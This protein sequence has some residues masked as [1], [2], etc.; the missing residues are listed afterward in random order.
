MSK[1]QDDFESRHEQI[2]Q[3]A[4]EFIKR[5]SISGI[6]GYRMSEFEKF[7]EML[8]EAYAPIHARQERE[9]TELNPLYELIRDSK[10]PSIS[11]PRNRRNLSRIVDKPLI[12]LLLV[13]KPKFRC[14]RL[15]QRAAIL[16]FDEQHSSSTDK[17]HFTWLPFAPTMDE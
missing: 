2:S 14:L 5:F 4:R 10:K 8:K 1:F 6:E 16:Q 17:I 7:N 13:I 3:R 15:G 11:V 12:E 9:T